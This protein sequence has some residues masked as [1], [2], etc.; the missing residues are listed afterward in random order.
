[1]VQPYPDPNIT[2]VLQ[3]IS[4]ANTVTDGWVTMLFLVTTSVIVLLI[5]KSKQYSTSNALTVSF[6]IT[7]IFSTFLWSAGLFEGNKVVL[8]LA[9]FMVTFLWS[10]FD[11]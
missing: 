2:G 5:L 9:L 4:Y 1:M 10:I 8:F 3:L 11:K 6:F 7:F